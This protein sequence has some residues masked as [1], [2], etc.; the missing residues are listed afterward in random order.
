MCELSCSHGA[1]CK[2][3]PQE[4][5]RSWHPQGHRTRIEGTSFSLFSPLIYPFYKQGSHDIASHTRYGEL[6]NLSN[7]LATVPLRLCDNLET[8]LYR[9]G[10]DELL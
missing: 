10:E 1:F 6:Q 5:Q 8:N 3:P 4:A 9:E 2:E 7:V